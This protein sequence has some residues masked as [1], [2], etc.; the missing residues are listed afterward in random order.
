MDKKKIDFMSARRRMASIIKIG[1]VDENFSRAYDFVNILAVLLN[2]AA[3][4]LLT[5]DYMEDNYG[6]LLLTVEA[7]TVAFFAAGAQGRPEA[8]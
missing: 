2:I 7:V 4:I 1:A 5:F 3:V 8:A 6:P